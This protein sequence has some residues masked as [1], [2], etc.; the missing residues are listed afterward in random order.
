MKNYNVEFDAE[1]N[2]FI[3]D[4]D[5]EDNAIPISIDIEHPK[6][7][8]FIDLFLHKDDT[9]RGIGYLQ[10]ISADKD[11]RLNEALFIAGLNNCMKCFKYSKARNKLDKTVV[12]VDDIQL[13]NEF[14]EFETM[15]DKHFDHDENGMTQATAFLLIS[16]SDDHIYGGPPSVVWNRSG[17]N[18]YLAGQR[19]QEIMRCVWQ[20]ICKEIDTVGGEIEES[21]KSFSKEELLKR[22]VAQIESPIEI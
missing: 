14:V 1:R 17:I 7:K 13:L 11:S 21:Y 22:S 19:L 15:R 9:E 18:Y 6:R 5:F 16:Q 8:Q 2:G 3:I 10:C 4:G 12:F 20:F